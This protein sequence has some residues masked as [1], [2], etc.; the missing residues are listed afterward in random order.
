[1]LATVEPVCL[2]ISDLQGSRLTSLL[3]SDKQVQAYLSPVI[4]IGLVYGAC[5]VY[6]LLKSLFHL[7][8]IL[9]E[10]RYTL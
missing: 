6:S 10:L 2:T 7:C 4:C 5:F 3:E 9:W 8:I 1:M